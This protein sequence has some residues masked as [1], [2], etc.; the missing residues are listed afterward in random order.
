VEETAGQT[1]CYG[2]EVIDCFYSPSNGGQ[3]KRS[4]DVW[5]RHYPYYINKADPWDAAAN[6]EKATKQSHG[7]GMSQVGAMWAA[8]NGIP[9]NDI[10]A[11]YY[12]GAAILSD[13]GKGGVVGFPGE[14][15]ETEGG[16]KMNLQKLIF[17][18]NACYKAGRTIT[19]KGIMVHS[20]GANNP[21]LRRYVGPDDGRLGPNQYN[22]HWNQ[23][24]PDG[25]QV[26]VHGFIGK[27]LD[28]SVA[29]Y[30]TLPWNHR[31]WHGGSGSKGSV[32]DTHIGF[33]ICEDGLTDAAYFRAVFN[34]A[35]ELCVHLCKMYDLDPMKDGVIIGHY[36]GH[37]RGIASNHGDPKNWFPKHGESMDSFRAAVKKGMGGSAPAPAPDPAPVTPAPAPSTGFNVGDIVQFA[38]GGVFTSSTSAAAA[39]TKR[40]ASRCKVTQINSGARYPYHLISEDKGGVWGWV[41][42]D[43]VSAIGQAPD[44]PF[45][46]YTVKVTADALNIRKGPGTDTAIVGDI[47]DKGVYTIVEEATGPGAN[48]WGRLKSGAGWISLDHT[49]KR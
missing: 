43:N 24:K 1:L 41:S 5:S 39:A 6:A 47:K 29:T 33:E 42:A 45:T 19:V 37:A 3:A 30:Q 9:Y 11:F 8:K 20:T 15:P 14:K 40:E 38:G 18:N 7:V 26:C 48:R 25:R 12:N 31:G 27:L 2:G 28:G 35:V 13:Y 23:D 21:T 16:S 44:A 32:N 46:A 10:L 36:E 17:V 4:G 22:N 34:E 49:Q